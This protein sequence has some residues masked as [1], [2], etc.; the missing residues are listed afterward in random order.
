MVRLASI[1]LGMIALAP[2]VKDDAKAFRVSL[3]RTRVIPIE[4]FDPWTLLT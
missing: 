1:V 2:D 4:Q 3:P